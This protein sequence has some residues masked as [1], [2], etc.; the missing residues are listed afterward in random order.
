VGKL[1]QAFWEAAAIKDMNIDRL[2][3][4]EDNN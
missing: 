1:P 2:I 4:D 3:K